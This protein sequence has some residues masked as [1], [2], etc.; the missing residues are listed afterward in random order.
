MNPGEKHIRS[1][2][3]VLAVAFL[4][5]VSGFLPSWF[6]SSSGLMGLQHQEQ[7]QV[8][9]TQAGRAHNAEQPVLRPA[10]QSAKQPGRCGVSLCTLL[11]EKMTIDER[12]FDSGRPTIQILHIPLCAP[13]RRDAGLVSMPGV[14]V[15]TTA[16]K[17][18]LHSTLLV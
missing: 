16:P 2:N 7:S 9:S 8:S 6:G 11:F 18:V 3:T 17:Y 1:V 10:D 14:P 15:V 4:L 5:I 12:D 13:D